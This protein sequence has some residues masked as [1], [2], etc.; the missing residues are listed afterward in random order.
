MII[1]VIIWTI[2]FITIA[3][4]Y[5]GIVPDVIS[6]FK[7]YDFF[8][9]IRRRIKYSK[10]CVLTKISEFCCSKKWIATK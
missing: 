7:E 4:S 5:V 1:N 8:G 2:M 6:M 9:E 10:D 3:V